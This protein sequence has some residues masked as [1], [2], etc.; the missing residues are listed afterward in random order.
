MSLA[1]VQFPGEIHSFLDEVA[2]GNI[3]NYSVVNKYGVN[4]D[5]DT[6]ADED[7]WSVGGLWVPPTTARLHDIASTSINDDSV[8]TGVQ[9][10]RVYGLNESFVETNEDIIMNGTTNVPT[11]NTY[12]AIF[13][14]KSLTV[15]SGGVPAGNITAIAGFNR[16]SPATT[17]LGVC[18]QVQESFDVATSPLLTKEEQ[19][20]STS[21]EAQ[22][23]FSF[24]PYRLVPEKSI[25]KLHAY[26]ASSNDVDVYGR[27]NIIKIDG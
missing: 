8:G 24:R 3:P 17:T 16:D 1:S 6:A 10:I 7:I 13:R 15:G 2:L 27:L 20:L 23:Q 26:G 4:S 12:T 5:V 22:A 9:T 18:L 11:V 21:N 19:I 14:M 25:V